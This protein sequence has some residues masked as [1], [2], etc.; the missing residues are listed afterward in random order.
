MKILPA[1]TFNDPNSEMFKKVAKK[2]MEKRII[3]DINCNQIARELKTHH[4][5]VLKVFSYMLKNF[6][7]FK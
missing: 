6:E 4:S 7:D 5:G 3:M 1:N 2:I